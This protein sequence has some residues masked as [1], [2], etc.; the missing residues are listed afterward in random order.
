MELIHA[1][2]FRS[3]PPLVDRTS[4]GWMCNYLEAGAGFGLL[5]GSLT[6]GEEGFASTG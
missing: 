5:S 3:R 1:P 2:N 6:G 4:Q